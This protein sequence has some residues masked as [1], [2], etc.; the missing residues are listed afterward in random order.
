MYLIFDLDDTL[1][2]SYKR[3]TKFTKDVLNSLQ[4]KGLSENILVILEYA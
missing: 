2:T 1:L 3:I 4:Q